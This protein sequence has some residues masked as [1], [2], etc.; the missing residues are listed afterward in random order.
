VLLLQARQFVAEVAIIVIVHLNTAW[1]DREGAW[2]R[3]EPRA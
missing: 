1:L 3:R 2:V